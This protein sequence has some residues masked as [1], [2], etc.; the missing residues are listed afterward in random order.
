MAA[1]KPDDI[2][3][4]L[5]SLGAIKIWPRDKPEGWHLHSGEWS[6]LYINLRGI[7]AAA[8][9][10]QALA[11]IGKAMGE[12][13]AAKTPQATRLVA[14]AT[15][16]IPIGIATALNTRMPMCY[17]RRLDN[18][19]TLPEL[20]KHLAERKAGNG[21]LGAYGEHELVEGELLDG[22]KV[23]IVDDLMTRG[24]TKAI[25]RRMIENTAKERSI[26]VEIVAICVVV[27]RQQAAKDATG[28]PVHSLVPFREQGLPFLK[29]NL[30]PALPA[31]IEDYLANPDDYQDPAARM[32]RLR[33]VLGSH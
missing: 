22:D 12:L 20:E 5:Y 32:Q 26:K 25:A 33:K 8:E 2:L 28:L 19:R 17:T 6:P 24:T 16:G 27:D 21:A 1:P 10:P 7:A 11:S 29:R 4:T 18:V 31:L 23:V 9:G 3:T 13:L 14:V 15:A 30:G